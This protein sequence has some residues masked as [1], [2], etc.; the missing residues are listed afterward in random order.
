MYV[1]T[2]VPWMSYL[3]CH[4]SID[5]GVWVKVDIICHVSY[6]LRSTCIYSLILVVHCMLST[7]IHVIYSGL[8][9]EDMGY[10]MA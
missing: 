1:S 3:L 4:P 7:I 5:T 9:I 6:P 8:S 2:D 10:S